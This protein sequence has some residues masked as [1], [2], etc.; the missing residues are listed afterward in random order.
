[1]PVSTSTMP[2]G[3]RMAKPMT[4]PSLPASGC[5]AG[6]VTSARWRGTTSSGVTAGHFRYRTGRVSV[7]RASHTVM[8]RYVL[9][10]GLDA[11]CLRSERLGG[12]RHRLCRLGLDL[13]GDRDRRADAAATLLL[14]D[15]LR[16]RGAAAGGMAR[17]SAGR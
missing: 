15:S 6:Y 9:R 3:C 11:A 2:S 4:G 13:P 5:D 1:M 16:A 10:H 17:L 14:G 8:R 7:G 12:P